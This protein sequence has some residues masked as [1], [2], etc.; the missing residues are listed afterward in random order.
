[1]RQVTSTTL[2]K[3][4]L[5]E[6][7]DQLKL[8]MFPAEDWEKYKDRYETVGICTEY[9]EMQCSV[10]E[11]AFE[12]KPELFDGIRWVDTEDGMPLWVRPGENWTSELLTKDDY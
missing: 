2:E 8:E 1:M 7:L 4:E 6:F 10:F 5:A 11:E 12:R 3:T 9:Y